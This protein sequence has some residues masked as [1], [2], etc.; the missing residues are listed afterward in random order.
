[1]NIIAHRGCAQQYP[2]NTLYACRQ[3]TPHVDMIELDVRRC[4]SGELVI[5]HDADLAR[6]A[7]DPRQIATT[8]WETLREITILDTTESI[9]R[10]TDVLDTVPAS[11]GLNLEIKE[12]AIADQL[13]AAIA[14]APQR[15]LVSS[16]HE[17]AL[18]TLMQSAPACE[19][20]L[21][22]P[23]PDRLRDGA[24]IADGKA[25]QTADELG[26]TAIHSHYQRCLETDLVAQAHAHG[27]MV[28]AW[29]LTDAATL[30]AVREAGVDGAIVDRL[31][32]V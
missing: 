22:Y 13:A 4:A 7:D 25:V 6:I 19:C 27:L 28:N 8:P 14:D 24:D 15:I 20:G 9:P 18:A 29:T 5:A 30:E 21:L 10:L 1:M 32:I 16:F 3:V 11:V 23:S 2:E 31:D 26:C 12:P 17:S